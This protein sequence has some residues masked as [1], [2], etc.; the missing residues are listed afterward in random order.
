M[1]KGDAKDLGCSSLVIGGLLSIIFPVVL[2]KNNIYSDVAW[3]LFMP[4]W[5]IFRPGAHDIFTILIATI[6][7]TIIF[8][9]ITFLLIYSIT[10]YFGGAKYE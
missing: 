2:I 6:L 7:D 4:G 10:K 1:L 8:A 3:L 9:A 5:L